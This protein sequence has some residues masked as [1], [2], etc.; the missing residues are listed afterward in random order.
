MRTLLGIAAVA[1][2]AFF[3]LV[4]YHAH[5]ER[6]KRWF[7]TLARLNREAVARLERDWTNLPRVPV[8]PPPGDH[9]YA[10]DLDV[11]GRAS[12][13]TLLGT[14]S[15]APGRALLR[16]WLLSPASPDEIAARQAA[17]AELA[18]SIDLRDE[19]AAGG[20]IAED[21]TP[22]ALE[23][24]LD[25]SESDGWLADRRALVWAARLIPP[26]TI[27]LGVLHATGVIGWPAWLLPLAAAVAVSRSTTKSIHA[28][29]DAAAAGETLAGYAPLFRRLAEPRLRAAGLAEIQETLGRGEEVADQ[30][31]SRLARWV[32]TSE[33]RESILRLVVQPL[34]LWDVHVLDG[35]E[36]WKR[37]DGDRV[38][39]WLEALGRAD[40]LAALAAL[41]HA[42][43]D[44]T[45]PEIE[46]D[47]P[48]EVEAED[49]RHP[50]LRPDE[51]V[52]NDA[53][54]G[55]PGTVLVVSGSN[56]AG[57]ST[58]LRAIG[59]S[60]VLAMAGGPVAA[61]RLRLPSTDLWTSM[62]VHDSLAEGVSL[63]MAELRRVRQI[64]DA[65]RSA[66]EERTVLY[67]LD[68]PLHGTNVA[69]RRV[70]VG[71]VLGLLVDAGAIGAVST[72]DMG[73]VEHPGLEEAARHVH[74]E[75][76]IEG[77]DASLALDF[78]YRLREG[79]AT[80]SNALAL[81]RLVGLSE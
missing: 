7:G 45:Y 29:F 33:M 32:Q 69:D 68:E 9:P 48:A 55:P 79:P 73:V 13:L 52:G 60:V 72:H 15:T 47:G 27:A 76:S 39:G 34:F 25:W 36:R 67:L 43:P 35:L 63:F 10:A 71:R 51:A 8:E 62:R 11:F 58:L 81:L 44:W 57:K 19:L 54:V 30:R 42:H 23:R 50:L 1:L 64:V 4:A 16:E 37:R 2:V 56:M 77:E 22:G 21:P 31:L 14:V 28:E 53:R 20:R 18:P 65:A 38:R 26:I 80:T 40:A 74:F 12:V 70:A 17:V 3:A 66:A 41:A 46:P 75:S 5:V 24:F 49:L 61:R 78:D 59:V 6:R